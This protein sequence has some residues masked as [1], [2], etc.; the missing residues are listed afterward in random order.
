MQRPSLRAPNAAA[1]DAAAE[2]ISAA[3]KPVL[4]L[5][6][7]ALTE[8]GLS[9]AARLHAAGLRVLTDTFYPIM[10]RGAGRFTPERM[11]YFAEGAMADLDGSDLMLLAGTTTPVAFFSY[12]G[13]PSVLVPDGCR[14]VSLGGPETDSAA[15]LAVLADR[16]GAHSKT[17]P[18]ELSVPA[19]P[20]GDLTAETIGMSITRHLPENALVSDDGVSNGL[21][22]YL[23]TANARPHD[24]T[25]LTGGADRTRYAAGARRSD[26][27]SRP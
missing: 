7:T 11:Q 10:A 26:C 22:S 6:G 3:Q 14:I 21:M 1:V 5:N 13:K 18:A 24:W 12:P 2:A 4:L 8:D 23:F 20:S 9:Q 15:T 27:G 25:M 17:A 16:L 19:C